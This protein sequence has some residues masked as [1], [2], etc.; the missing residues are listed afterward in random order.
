MIG[1]KSTNPGT[2]GPKVIKG[3]FYPRPVCMEI[4]GKQKHISVGNISKNQKLNAYGDA[5]PSVPQASINPSLMCVENAS[6]KS[7]I[8]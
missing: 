2:R 5:N 4:D 3:S 7:P 6:P 8:L 1:G